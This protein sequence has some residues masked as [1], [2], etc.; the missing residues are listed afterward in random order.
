VHVDDVISSGFGAQSAA[1]VGREREAVRRSRREQPYTGLARS[2]DEVGVAR[3]A[4]AAG[5]ARRTSEIGA[6][7]V[8]VDAGAAEG[9]RCLDDADGRPACA[10]DK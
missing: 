8:D 5:G 10:P 9:P 3:A 6:E 7:D 4:R 2:V 1:E